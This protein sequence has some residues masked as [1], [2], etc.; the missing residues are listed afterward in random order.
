MSTISQE[1]AI[2]NQRLASERGKRE[3][4]NLGKIFEELVSIFG[5]GLHLRT[6]WIY[7]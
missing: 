4:T 3:N 2:G 5:I 1:R 7:F 6:N